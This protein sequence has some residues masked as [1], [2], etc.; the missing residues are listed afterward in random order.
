MNRRPNRDGV[1]AALE[2]L[3]KYEHMSTSPL[4]SL[5]SSLLLR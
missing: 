3:K 1:H 2:A 5:P 4:L